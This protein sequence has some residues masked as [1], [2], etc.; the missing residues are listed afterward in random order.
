[1]TIEDVIS[2]EKQNNLTLS[3]EEWIAAYSLIKNQYKHSLEGMSS[4][5]GDDSTPKRMA[6][7]L[8]QDQ[9]VRDANIKKTELLQKEFDAIREKKKRWYKLWLR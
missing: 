5:L 3:N 8:M 6:I 2:Y 7:Q 9:E 1:M 4:L